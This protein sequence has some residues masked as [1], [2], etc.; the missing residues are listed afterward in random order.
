[1]SGTNNDI[2]VLDSNPVL[3]NYLEN[4]VHDLQFEVDDNSHRGYYLLTDSIY[5]LWAIFVQTLHG[6]QE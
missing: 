2:N 6:A 4:Q 1:M 5:P 3:H